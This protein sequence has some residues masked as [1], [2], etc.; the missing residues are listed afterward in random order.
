MKHIIILLI[1]AF[2]GINSLNAQWYQ[3]NTNTTENLY[4]IFFVDSLEGYCVG[5]GDYFGF[6]QSNGLILKSTDGGE[7]WNSIFSVDSM[8]IK[9]LAIIEQGGD[10]K[11]YAFA[12]KSGMP[13]LISTFINTS[14]QNWSVSQI[15]Y[16][17]KE[18][19][20]YNNEI[21]FIDEL[22]ASLKK[23]SNGVLVPLHSSVTY[24]D[25]Q[26]SDIVCLDIT[27]YNIYN[28]PDLGVNWDTLA[29]YPSTFQSSNISNGSIK[30]DDNYII[31]KGTYPGIVVYTL[32]N[33]TN[34]TTNYNAPEFASTIL[35]SG[36]IIGLTH[37]DEIVSSIDLGINWTVIGMFNGE[38][39]GA[40]IKVFEYG[41]G[42]LI[43]NGGLMYKGI[44]DTT[45]VGIN[46]PYLKKKINIYPNPTKDIL[47]IEVL[48]SL[49]I[50]EIALFDIEGKKVKAFN[51]KDRTL[52]VSG[53]ISGIYILKLS[54][55]GGVLTRKVVIE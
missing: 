35:S 32:N 10:M 50:E 37:M 9:N 54:T 28:S 48:D 46:K 12:S 21:F 6:P 53:V 44:I 49:K 19:K 41:Y 43:G 8:T 17:P 47:Q 16:K 31:L 30:I 20:T 11:L 26:N 15:S 39:V 38:K 45:A 34:W 27:S 4:D 22:D 42:F 7:S 55:K 52:N 51:K 14:I 40:R 13:Y 29:T 18:V 3:V 5:G 36:L 23:L 24:F 2:F 1:V 33:G 25:V